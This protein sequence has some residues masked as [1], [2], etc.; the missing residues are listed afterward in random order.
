[1]AFAEFSFI[2]QKKRRVHLKPRITRP[3]NRIFPVFFVPRE[4]EGGVCLVEIE[5]GIN[6]FSMLRWGLE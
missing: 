3:G 4:R 5:K 6:D 2:R 1:M